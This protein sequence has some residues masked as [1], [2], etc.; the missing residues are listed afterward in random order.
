MRQCLSAKL[1]IDFVT[2]T[3][4]HFGAILFRVHVNWRPHDNCSTGKKAT[5]YKRSK[6]TKFIANKAADLVDTL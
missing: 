2:A 4:L 3:P 5:A 6:A 1:L